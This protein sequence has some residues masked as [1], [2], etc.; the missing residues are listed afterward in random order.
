MKDKKIKV[1]NYTYVSDDGVLVIVAENEEQ[2][3]KLLAE[4]VQHPLLWGLDE[5][6]LETE[7]EFYI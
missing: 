5:D 6:L 7:E 4:Q 2:S 1:K 3:R